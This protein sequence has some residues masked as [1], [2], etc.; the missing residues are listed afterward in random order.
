MNSCEDAKIQD[1]RRDFA[2]W[3]IYEDAYGVTGRRRVDGIP[4]SYTAGSAIVLR[5]HLAN[6]EFRD[7]IA[8]VLDRSV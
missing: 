1:L 7:V 8:A 5:S 6:A 4:E 2:H 3:I